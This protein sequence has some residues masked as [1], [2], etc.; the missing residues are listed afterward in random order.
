MFLVIF[1]NIF[2]LSL[3]CAEDNRECIEVNHVYGNKQCT[4]PL[5][6][7]AGRL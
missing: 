3:Y 7:E 2:Y 5:P 4:Q 6:A 1:L